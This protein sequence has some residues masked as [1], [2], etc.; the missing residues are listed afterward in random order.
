M[1][2]NHWIIRIS[3]L[4]L[5]QSLLN[6]G[7]TYCLTCLLFLV[8]FFQQLIILAYYLVSIL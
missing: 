4:V 3:L 1:L 8:F 7:C 6:D 2:S 5:S